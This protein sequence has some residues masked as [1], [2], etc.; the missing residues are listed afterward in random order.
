MTDRSRIDT[1]LR[2]KNLMATLMNLE[3]LTQDQIEDVFV[4]AMITIEENQVIAM[5]QG[6]EDFEF[7]DYSVFNAY[8]R[9]TL[10]SLPTETYFGIIRKIVK[11][12]QDGYLSEN[13]VG[14]LLVMVIQAMG[15]DSERVRMTIGLDELS[16]LRD[17]E[18]YFVDDLDRYNQ[19]ISIFFTQE[20]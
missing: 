18:T 20:N 8:F 14:G 4:R 15:I 3:G 7:K 17:I 16:L 1:S 5:T 9:K 19:S 2:F 11:E 12:V 10:K 13:I 6:E